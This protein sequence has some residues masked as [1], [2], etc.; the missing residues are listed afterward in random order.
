[1]ELVEVEQRFNEG[2]DALKKSLQETLRLFLPPN[3]DGDF[4]RFVAG[5]LELTFETHR[6][7]TMRNCLNQFSSPTTHTHLPST[8][9]S[10]GS[11][12]PSTTRAKRSSRISTVLYS[13]SLPNTP[14]FPTHPA[15][16]VEQVSP[17]LTTTPGTH[18]LQRSQST[19]SSNRASRLFLTLPP[20]AIRPL[21]TSDTPSPQTPATRS[22]ADNQSDYD[23]S[24]E[25]RDSGIGIP[26]E[27]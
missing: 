12:E 27:V 7:N 15:P 13:S 22:I 8:T 26:C 17:P 16:N 18:P 2:Q 21:T 19:R 14:R 23:C 4:C 25:S 5:Q 20:H 1:M 3:I 24:R 6:A 10:S 9:Q 11:T